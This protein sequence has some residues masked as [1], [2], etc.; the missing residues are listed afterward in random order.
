MSLRVIAVDWSGDKSR[1]HRKIWLAEVSGGELVRL[2]SGRDRR[3]VTDHLI[4]EAERDTA[5]V[6]GL[7]FAFSL[8]AWYLA[9]RDLASA[10]DL[11]DV[12]DRE[13]EE[14]L[15]ECA[16]PFW[17][18]RDRCCP[19]LL[20][21]FRRTERESPPV[22]G[23]QPKSVFQIGGAGAVG[24]GSLRG[25]PCLKR[26]RDAGFSIWPFDSPGWPSVVEIYPRL[27][28]G[29]VNKGNKAARTEYLDRY[30]E[31]APEFRERAAESEDAFD[32]AISALVMAAY[33]ADL[34]ELRPAIDPE[35]RREGVI[36]RPALDPMQ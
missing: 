15:S 2:E 24:T 28:T 13:A 25:M 30:P 16:P 14:W 8:P 26:L 29:P 7:D 20:E 4:A 19:E 18:R 9:E 33:A 10:V 21:H 36:W 22:T 12:A 3:A 23:I 6:V 17:G 11:W 31:L 34:I 27:L 1:S 35:L 32:A 5:M